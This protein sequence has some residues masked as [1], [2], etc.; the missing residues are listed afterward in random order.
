[1]NV[2]NDNL[3]LDYWY[4]LSIDQYAL[5][6]AVPNA[7]TNFISFDYRQI[8]TMPLSRTQ[9]QQNIANEIMLGVTFS[10]LFIFFVIWFSVKMYRKY[11]SSKKVTDKD[12][13]DES[14]DPA[15]SPLRKKQSKLGM[16]E[17]SG[18]NSGS[19]ILTPK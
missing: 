10:G 15:S 5:V 19:K 9:Q 6:V 17:K 11:K 1:M 3:T 13:Q 8:P 2:T 12:N 18:D 14:M 16:M 7:E 4:T